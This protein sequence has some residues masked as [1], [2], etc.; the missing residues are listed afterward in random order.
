MGNPA[1]RSAHGKEGGEHVGGDAEGMQ[2]DAGIEI[3][4]RVKFTAIE[5][6]VFECNLFK[7]DGQFKEGAVMEV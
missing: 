6:L 5:V 2:H 4:I 7:F 3:D 1:D